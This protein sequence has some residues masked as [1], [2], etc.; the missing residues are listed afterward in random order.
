MQEKRKKMNKKMEMLVTRLSADNNQ[1]RNILRIWLIFTFFEILGYQLNVIRY[2]KLRG[3]YRLPC[4]ILSLI[5]P[6][7]VLRS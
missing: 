7:L 6:F 3:I 2:F 5:G 4:Y 1:G